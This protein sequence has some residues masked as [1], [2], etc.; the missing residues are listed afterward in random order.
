M[1]MDRMLLLQQKQMENNQIN[2][3]AFSW[4]AIFRAVR[5]VKRARA[6]K[7]KEIKRNK[8][9][10]TYFSLFR[11]KWKINVYNIHAAADRKEWKKEMKSYQHSNKSESL[12]GVAGL[13]CESRFSWV[14]FLSRFRPPSFI[15][16]PSLL[17][18]RWM[19]GCIENVCM[20]SYVRYYT[21]S[22]SFSLGRCCCCCIAYSQTR[23][24]YFSPASGC[25]YEW[26]P[27][28]FSRSRPVLHNGFKRDPFF[29]SFFS[30]HSSSPSLT[31][32]FSFSFRA[33]FYSF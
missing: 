26:W 3:G 14:F 18:L 10:A 11:G 9:S 2:S 6:R 25:L 29:F 31:S 7:K 12:K 30:F 16:L 20:H 22:T 13:N 28:I 1:E 27:I 32:F 24:P 8:S 5:L 17:P 21:R 15:F 33:R 4:E 23:E 19:D